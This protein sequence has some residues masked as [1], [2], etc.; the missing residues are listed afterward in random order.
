MIFLALLSGAVAYRQNY[1]EQEVEDNRILCEEMGNSM[2][3]DNA[4]KINTAAEQKKVRQKMAGTH[5]VFRKRVERFTD[6][7]LK[8]I[9]MAKSEFKIPTN[10]SFENYIKGFGVIIEQYLNAKDTGDILSVCQAYNAGLL[11]EALNVIKTQ[12]MEQMDEVLDKLDE[13]G[14]TDKPIINILK[15][16]KS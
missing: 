6:A 15:T 9:E 12:A 4:K 8:E 11:D 10:K 14:K 5:Y 13:F 3:N 2:V 1:I 7:C 16:F